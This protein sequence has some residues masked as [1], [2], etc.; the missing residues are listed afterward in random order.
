MTRTASVPRGSPG[1]SSPP[2]AAIGTSPPA[3][4]RASSTTPAASRALCET[5][6]IPTIAA[7]PPSASEPVGAVE[8]L[9]RMDRRDAGGVGDLPAA[10]LGVADRHRRR[11]RRAPASNSG[12]PTA[13][14][15]SYFSRL[16][17]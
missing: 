7:P 13:M 9:D 2:A 14:P 15:M 12:C 10:G 3:I 8:N 16:R 6:T 11:R 17:P 5:T 4:S 1:S